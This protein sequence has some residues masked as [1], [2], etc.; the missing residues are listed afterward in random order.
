MSQAGRQ[1]QPGLELEIRFRPTTTTAPTAAAGRPTETKPT[2]AGSASAN[3]SS[4][5]AQSGQRAAPTAKSTL[6]KGT[7]LVSKPQTI[8][9]MSSQQSE[10]AEADSILQAGV[11]P[12]T[13]Q[14]GMAAPSPALICRTGEERCGRS[15]HRPD[16]TVE[17]RGARYAGRSLGGKRPC[18]SAVHCQGGRPGGRAFARAFMHGPGPGRACDSEPPWPR[19]GVAQLAES[20]PSGPGQPGGARAPA[21]AGSA[22]R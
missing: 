2:R 3:V 20:G 16:V 9:A 18:R 5:E 7:E 1:L 4:A 19:L 8:V 14:V 6:C 12:C 13:V 17:T 21:A 11:Q 22:T 15:R 10:V